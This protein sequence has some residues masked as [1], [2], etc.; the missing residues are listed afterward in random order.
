[1]LKTSQSYLKNTDDDAIIH[2]NFGC[3]NYHLK[4]YP[5]ALDLYQQAL[6]INE[7]KNRFSEAVVINLYNLSITYEAMGN[8]PSAKALG[9]KALETGKTI[10]SSNFKIKTLSDLYK[11]IL[12][13]EIKVD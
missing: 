3:I 13:P 1:M 10:Y 6:M 2:N 4:D 8:A 12:L 7:K 5:A 9:E 11:S